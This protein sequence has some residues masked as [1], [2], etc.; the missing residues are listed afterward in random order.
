MEDPRRE[1]PPCKEI[2]SLLSSFVDTFVDFSVSGLF[3]L[4]DQNPDDHSTPLQTRYPAATRLIAIGDIHGDLEKAR[5]SLRLAGLVDGS[6]KW[7]GG[8]TML[9]QIGDVLDRGDH[10]LKI[11]YF[12]EKLRREAARAGGTIVSMNGNHEIMNV[13]GDFR[14]VTQ[15]GVEEFSI[16]ADWYRLGIRMKSL[17]SGLEK[18]E[19]PFEG[20]PSGFKNVRKEYSDGFRARIA[21]L[22]PSGPIS[23]RFLSKNVTVAVVG[24]SVF[25]HGGLLSDHVVNHGLEKM[26][27]E[28]RD[29]IKGSKGRGAPAPSYCRR[30]DA[31]VWLRSFSH[32]AAERCDCETLEHVLGTIPGAKRMIMGHTI[33]RLGIN[34]VCDDRAIRIDVGMSKGCINGL[35]EVLEINGDSKP[36][37]LTSNPAHYKSPAEAEPEKREGLGLLLPEHGPKQVQVKA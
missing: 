19:D 1:E 32:E 36:R 22:R 7:V 23:T 17:C 2:P 4:P 16:W 26:N 27:Q 25:V 37:I 15:K 30:A 33:Q 29:W 34:G 21:A 10:E 28:V 8:S 18:P 35:P 11:L 9:V 5:Q 31:V 6:D 13:E 14:F 12:I 20:L 24:G 3:L